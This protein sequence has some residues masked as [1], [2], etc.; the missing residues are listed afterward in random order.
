ME[1]KYLIP[2]YVM[3]MGVKH[4]VFILLIRKLKT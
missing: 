3:E 2:V 4:V 1:N